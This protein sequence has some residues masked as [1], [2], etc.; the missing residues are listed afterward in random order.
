MSN[1]IVI[2]FSGHTNVKETIAKFL[3]EK[4]GTPKPLSSQ[5]INLQAG[6]YLYLDRSIVSI[7]LAN[8]RHNIIMFSNAI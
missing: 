6:N 3:S 4:L 8:V 7:Y 5:N 2:H 1:L